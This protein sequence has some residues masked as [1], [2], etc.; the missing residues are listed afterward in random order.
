M[1][2]CNHTQLVG[3][4][5]TR[6]TYHGTWFGASRASQVPLGRCTCQKRVVSRLDADDHHLRDRF[7]CL[8]IVLDPV[9]ALDPQTRTLASVIQHLDHRW[10]YTMTQAI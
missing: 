10:H 2:T 3:P 5:S 8:R 1:H 4:I 6:T 9:D 7:T